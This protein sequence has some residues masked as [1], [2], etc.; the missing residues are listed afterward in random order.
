VRFEAATFLYAH[1]CGRYIAGRH[2]M[3]K[4][5]PVSGLE[6]IARRLAS[7]RRIIAWTNGC[8][9]LLHVGHV[10]SLRSA[11]SLGNVLVVGVNSDDMVRQL[12]GPGRPVITAAARAEM[13]A[14]LDCVDYVT[15]FDD[16]T[17]ERCLLALR[18]H[19]HCKGADY[20]PPDGKPI[21]E[22]KVVASYGGRVE[23]L[24]LLAGLST[25]ELIRRIK[26]LPEL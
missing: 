23:F 3:R 15:I 6:D 20:A 17:P 11:R 16:P 14:A 10:H 2:L 12:K 4:V 5:I 19:I 25:T 24:P 7:E 13:V 8:F 18:P 21:P 22:A 9:D 26:A 1:Q